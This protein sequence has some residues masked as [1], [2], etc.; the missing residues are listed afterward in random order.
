MGS[1]QPE[2]ERSPRPR[3][4]TVRPPST[5]PGLACTTLT[6]RSPAYSG[7]YLR[8]GRDRGAR[9]GGWPRHTVLPDRSSPS[10][11]VRHLRPDEVQHGDHPARVRPAIAPRSRARR[12]DGRR[13]SRDAH[14]VAPAPRAVRRSEHPEQCDG[15][16][17]PHRMP[18]VPAGHTRV[19]GCPL[20]VLAMVGILRTWSRLSTVGTV[21][22]ALLVSKSVVPA[23]GSVPGR[24]VESLRNVGVR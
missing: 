23:P 6:L 11:G 13:A 16:S 20:M 22:S 21:R 10:G 15:V 19:V 9:R 12:A 18:T 8:P 17:T 7:R 2:H 5:Q 14:F 1:D 3:S 4:R 24:V